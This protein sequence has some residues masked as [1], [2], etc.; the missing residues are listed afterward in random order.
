MLGSKVGREKALDLIEWDGAGFATIVEVHVVGAG[1]NN[2]LLVLALQLRERIFAHVARVRV[3]AV[4]HHDG[5][6]DFVGKLQQVGVQ[7]RKAW[8]GVPIVAGVY[9]ELVETGGA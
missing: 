5:V 9:R 1:D 6:F 4:H 7:P 3:L 8:G 2:E